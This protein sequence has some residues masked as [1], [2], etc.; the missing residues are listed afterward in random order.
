VPNC[1][2]YIPLQD[3][4]VK[5]P[6]YAVLD[7]TSE[8]HT[9]A[10]LCTAVESLTLPTRMK[11]TQSTGW[12]MSDISTLIDIAGD[13]KLVRLQASIGNNTVADVN[14]EEAQDLDIDLSL[15]SIVAKDTWKRKIFG[16]F[17]IRRGEE[18]TAE[19][20]GKE[21]GAKPGSVS[22]SPK[23]RDLTNGG[24]RLQTLVTPVLFPLLDS[25]PQTIFSDHRTPNGVAVNASLATSSDF[26]EKLV[27]L[28]TVAQRFADSAE[29]EDL[30]AQLSD[31]ADAYRSG[32]DS[33][34]DDSEDDE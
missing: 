29:R 19:L 27:G 32:W 20:V 8:W 15:G 4:P 2:L 16:L 21:Q 33:A 26:I 24:S 9:S 25:F 28:K 18:S 17:N 23:L 7:K 34:E 13:Q 12:T 1:S 5:L 3:P 6:S 22:A 11:P 10:L 31:L 30:A 14:L